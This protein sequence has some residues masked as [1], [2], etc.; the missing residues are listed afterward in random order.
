MIEIK[1]LKKEF[2]NETP[3]KDLSLT[4]NDGDVLSIIGPSGTGKSTFLRML[5][6]LEKPSAGQIIIN[7]E[8]ITAKNYSMEKIRKK[9]GMVFQNFNLFNNLSVIENVCFGPINIKNEKPKKALDKGMEL[10]ESVGLAKHAFAYPESLSGGQKQRVAIA[11]ALSMEPEMLLFDE[12]TSALD[13][14]MVSEVEAVMRQL[15][16][17]G[18]TMIIVTHDMELAE[19]L[20]NKVAFFCDGVLYEE[21]TPEE[22]FYNPSKEK[23]KAFVMKLRNLHLEIDSPQYDFMSLYSSIDTFSKKNFMDYDLTTKVV[24]ILEELCF[25]MII[26]IFKKIDV[27]NKKIVIDISYSDKKKSIKIM[28]QWENIFFNFDNDDYMIQRK[29]IEHYAKSVEFIETNKVLLKV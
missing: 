11:R 22:I 21:G 5:N 16:D 13:P 8:D 27:E 26:P 4:I 3:I 6:M 18:K 12:P 28:I 24:A 15:A 29:L 19:K 14:S 17:K 2:E 7:G 20:S 9:V 25:G 10:L 23:T 1:N